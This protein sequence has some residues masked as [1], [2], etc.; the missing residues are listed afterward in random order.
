MFECFDLNVLKA[1]FLYAYLHVFAPY[2]GRDPFS[3]G[4]NDW[5]FYGLWVGI[6]QGK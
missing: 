2:E 6:E 3:L 1:Y 5:T 4:Y